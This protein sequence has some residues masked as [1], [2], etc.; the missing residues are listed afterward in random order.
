[1]TVPE[2]PDIPSPMLKAL[3][4]PS[5]VNLFL[6][7]MEGVTDW[8]MRDTLSRLGGLDFCVTEFLRVTK[9]LHPHKVFLRHCPELL[10]GSRTSSGTPVFFQIL[11]GEPEPMALNA[12][13]AAELGAA[14]ID[15]NFGC[16]AKTVNRHDG[17]AVLLKSPQ[18]LFTITQRVRELVPKEI[19]V[20]VKMRLG[21]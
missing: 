21:F 3:N 16:P 12:L 6:A 1:M 14:G 7:P 4:D 10:N 20:S 19:P 9:N 13:R 11:G 15:L 8:I 18:R 5:K 2:N 17:G